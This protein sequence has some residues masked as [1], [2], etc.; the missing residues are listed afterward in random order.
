MLQRSGR[1]SKRPS[2]LAEQLQSGTF[3]AAQARP[4]MEDRYNCR[5]AQRTGGLDNDPWC[6]QSL[7]RLD[8]LRCLDNL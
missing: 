1:A 6:D 2:R 8:K 3:R 5:V 7:V 4:P